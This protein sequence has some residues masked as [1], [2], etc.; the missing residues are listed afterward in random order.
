MDGF[1]KLIHLQLKSVQEREIVYVIVN[2]C[3]QVF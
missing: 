1:E 2:C 3:L